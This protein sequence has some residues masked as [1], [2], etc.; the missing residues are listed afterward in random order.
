M[1]NSFLSFRL[2]LGQS[3]TV[4]ERMRR[5]M[6]HFNYDPRLLERSAE[7]TD[8]QELI[9]RGTELRNVLLRSFVPHE[10]SLD[11]PHH[12]QDPEE[13]HYL[14]HN[15]LE[16][17]SRLSGNGAGA[18]RDD[19]RIRSWAKRYQ[20]RDPVVIEGDPILS[21]L[22]ASQIRAMALMIGERISLV[23]GVDLFSLV[24]DDLYFDYRSCFRS[25]RV[26]E[27]RRRLLRQSTY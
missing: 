9:L 10:S 16:H 3:N 21:G 15:I 12:V 19:C 14:D 11:E 24:L 22:N 23:Q 13:P 6:S 2:D 27:R 18:F 8:A 1:I 7:N 26:L 5:A 4:F 25:H 17:P 20:R